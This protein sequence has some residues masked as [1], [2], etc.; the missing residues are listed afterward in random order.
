MVVHESINVTE[1]EL[2]FLYSQN[3]EKY[4]YAIIMLF[5]AMKHDIENVIVVV[6]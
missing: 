6:I 2:N 3:T 4:T 5:R 1:S